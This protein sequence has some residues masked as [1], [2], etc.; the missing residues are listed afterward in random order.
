MIDST[1]ECTLH[2][3]DFVRWYDLGADDIMVRETG[4]G[5]I[6]KITRYDMYREPVFTFGILCG[7]GII[8]VF[9]RRHLKFLST[10]YE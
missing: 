2:E 6:I 1:F 4:L 3:S 7:D 8:R 9:E 10:V 5:V